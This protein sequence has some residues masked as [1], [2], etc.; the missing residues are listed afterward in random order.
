MQTERQEIINDLR[1]KGV[2]GDIQC[3][4]SGAAAAVV[5]TAFYSLDF[6]MKQD[7]VG[8]VYAFCFDGSNDHTSVKLRDI[9]TNEE[10]GKFS[11]MFGL[12][13]D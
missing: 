9:R 4:E 5:D 1:R 6:K 7:F 3:R 13:L 2:F 12:K 8:V 11:K 10:V